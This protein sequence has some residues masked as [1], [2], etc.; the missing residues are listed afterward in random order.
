LASSLRLLVRFGW[1]LSQYPQRVSVLHPGCLHGRIGL[2]GMGYHLHEHKKLRAN[3]LSP[4]E[5][6]LAPEFNS[7]AFRNIQDHLA[8]AVP[9]IH[10]QALRFHVR[11]NA[12]QLFVSQASGTHDKSVFLYRQYNRLR[13]ALQHVLPPFSALSVDIHKLSRIRNHYLNIKLHFTESN[14]WRS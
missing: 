12:L 11:W 4:R 6:S 5:K 3:H 2:F 7:L 13:F 1:W 14:I 9:A 8:F 10:R